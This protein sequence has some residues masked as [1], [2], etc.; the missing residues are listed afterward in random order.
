[1]YPHDTIARWDSPGHNEQHPKCKDDLEPVK[2]TK[3]SKHGKRVDWIVKTALDSFATIKK[4]HPEWKLPNVDVVVRM[5]GTT[6]D[7]NVQQDLRDSDAPT[8][9]RKAEQDDDSLWYQQAES[10]LA[11][12]IT[13]RAIK[14][15]K[16]MQ[17]PSTR[18]THANHRQYPDKE[19][20][21]LLTDSKTE[22]APVSP[23]LKPGVDWI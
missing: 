20:G 17:H 9:D 21:D 13:R 5:T 4:E 18:I 11:H 23:Y 2:A 6:A 16:L 14:K 19:V 3:Q 10:R 22:E 12:T 7:G 15:L 1:M 8:F